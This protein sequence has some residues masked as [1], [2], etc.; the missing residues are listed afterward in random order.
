M[1]LENEQY[2]HM[3]KAK[4][5]VDDLCHGMYMWRGTKMNNPRVKNRVEVENKRIN[6]PIEI[7]EHLVSPVQYGYY[8]ANIWQ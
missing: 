6:P 4:N 7:K 3:G 1:E 8:G 5:V 2:K